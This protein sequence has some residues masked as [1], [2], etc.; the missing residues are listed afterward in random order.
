MDKSRPRSRRLVTYGSSTKSQLQPKNVP[1]RPS[2]VNTGKQ[3]SLHLSANELSEQGRDDK[4]PPHPLNIAE[5]SIYDLSS[6]DDEH[7]HQIVQR[8]RRRHS[9][10]INPA[11]A[12]DISD[13]RS[14]PAVGTTARPATMSVKVE[15]RPK[16]PLL[17]T[18]KITQDN[19]WL[20]SRRDGTSETSSNKSSKESAIQSQR[21]ASRSKRLSDEME[22][23]ESR[24]SKA[25][26][27]LKELSPH[28]PFSPGPAKVFMGSITPGRKRLID[29]LGTSEEFADVPSPNT[30]T[31]SQ[32]SSP[33]VPHTPT[34]LRDHK[35]PSLPSENQ[36]ENQH[37]NHSQ[38]SAIAPSP[39]LRSSKVTYARQRSFLDDLFLE[40]ALSGRASSAALELND[41]FSQPPEAMSA[42]PRA[43]LF[44]REDENNDYGSVR[45]IHELR[46]AGG[47][48]RYRGAV[49]SIFEDIEDQHISIS[50]R[51]NAFIQLCGKLLDPK[52]ASQFVECNFDKRLVDCLS[53][54]FDIVSATLA[55]S[56]LSLSFIGRSLPYIL[57]TVAWPKLLDVSAVM[58]DT[59]D[60]ISAVIRAQGSKISKH[61]QTSVQN[62]ALQILTAL[63]HDT[64][65]STLSPCLIALHCL[66]ATVASF[67]G[68]GERPSGLPLPLLEQLIDL[69]LPGKLYMGGNSEISLGGSHVFILGLSILEAHTTSGGLLQQNHLSI[70]S[71]LPGL[72][73]LLRVK[74]NESEPN[75]QLIQ[76]L[77][78]RIILNVT[79]SNPLLCDKFATPKILEELAEIVMT[80]FGDLTE[81]SQ[82]SKSLDTVI[83]ALGALINLTEQSEAIR[84]VFINSINTRGSL[85][86]RLLPLFLGHVHS[87]SKADSFPKVNQNVAVGY[88]A[89]LLLALCLNPK[90]RSHIKQ[91][92]QAKGLTV[93]M[94]TVDEFLHYHRKIEQDQYPSQ[95]P[96]E[97]GGFH[98]SLEDLICQIRQTQ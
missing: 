36:H 84:S 60:D 14:S 18:R 5:K 63:S 76:T 50:G 4:T 30:P 66:G 7:K 87:T 12:R 78:I 46:Q 1:S 43:R 32:N 19:K 62:I 55:F 91:S 59:H 11:L 6:S 37:G 20:E 39:H 24:D 98:V 85:L 17:Q 95:A 54:D 28:T 41:P 82:G 90:A 27:I 81:N 49:E 83:L 26:L 25:K 29:S 48:A 74:I 94:S 35:S 73:G 2:A 77:Y 31:D 38:E 10:D 52:L 22:R 23:E 9:R 89:V 8:K 68:K 61:V 3:Q 96:K 69:L 71:S 88:L 34:R 64:P 53:K 47:N 65:V 40:D 70:L 21:K 16:T 45:S 72:H 93:V 15:P 80:N 79:N 33:V 56:A 51:C 86:D 92:F 42:F 57:A 13:S 58:L 44:S 97:L 75:S 67:Q